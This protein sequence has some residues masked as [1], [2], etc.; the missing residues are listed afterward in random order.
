M[1]FACHSSKAAEARRNNG[2]QIGATPVGTHSCSIT[3]SN[4]TTHLQLS[5]DAALAA[6]LQ[7]LQSLRPEVLLLVRFCPIMPHGEPGGK[8]KGQPMREKNFLLDSHREEGWRRTGH[9]GQSC[10]SVDRWRQQ[11]THPSGV[12]VS[13]AGGQRSPGEGF[14]WRGDRTVWG[15]KVKGQCGTCCQWLDRWADYRLC[16]RRHTAVTAVSSLLAT[17]TDLNGER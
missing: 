2:K 15:L 5:E 4:S 12:C 11:H 1:T 3:T 14:C 17:S 6:G 10:V 8:V 16:R 9:A 7:I 13:E